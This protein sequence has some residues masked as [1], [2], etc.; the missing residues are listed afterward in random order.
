MG[1]WPCVPQPC[2]PHTKL[3]SLSGNESGIIFK[4]NIPTYQHPEIASYPCGVQGKSRREKKHGVNVRLKAL[5]TLTC[6]RTR[7]WVETNSLFAESA[8]CDK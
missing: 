4:T 5:A 3:V 6:L 7:R 1:V 8:G 2:A